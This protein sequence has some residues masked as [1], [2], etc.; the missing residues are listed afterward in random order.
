MESFVVLEGPALWA[1]LQEAGLGDDFVKKV[2][3]RLSSEMGEI[4]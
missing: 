4:T 3:G 2:K 1:F